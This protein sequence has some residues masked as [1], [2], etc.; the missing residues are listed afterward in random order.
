MCSLFD[1]CT[2]TRQAYI[3]EFKNKVLLFVNVTTLIC[4][5]NLVDHHRDNTC[6]TFLQ[7]QPSRV[8]MV[9]LVELSLDIAQGCLYLEENHFIHRCVCVCVCVCVR[10]RVCECVCVSVSVWVCVCV[11]MFVCVRAC[12]CVCVCFC[13]CMCVFL[14]VC[15]CVCFFV[16]VCVCV[17]VCLCVCV[18]V[19]VCLCVCVGVCVC[20]GD[21]RP[22]K[23]NSPWFI[24]ST[25]LWKT[26]HQRFP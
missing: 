7:R 10:A 19:C 6:I 5:F 16:C 2:I 4:S 21:N 20:A 22:L 12:V 26:W 1:I 3:W 8:T 14:C 11:C 17:S 24:S 25:I 15:V 9:D 13:V 23:F 18:C